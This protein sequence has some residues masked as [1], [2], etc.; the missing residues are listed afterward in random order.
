MEKPKQL[1]EKEIDLTE[2]RNVCQGYIDFIDND[3]EYYEDNDYDHYIFE[4]A[5]TTI[6]GKDVFDWINQRQD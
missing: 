6:F 1:S 5:M 4:K 3:K 2:L